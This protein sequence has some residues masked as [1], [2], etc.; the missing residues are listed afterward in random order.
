[1]AVRGIECRICG[2]TESFHEG[3]REWQDEENRR[4]TLRGKADMTWLDSYGHA[5]ILTI[6][7]LCQKPCDLPVLAGTKRHGYIGK[8]YHPACEHTHY[9]E[10]DC[11]SWPECVPCG[12]S[13]IE[14][15]KSMLK[16]HGI[17]F[18]DGD[19]CGPEMYEVR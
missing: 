18:D 2:Y 8:V 13:Q 14:Y 1:M 11:D 17:A 6:C 19:A 10:C 16:K 7:H 5:F 15:L 12:M 9:W 3:G 4:V